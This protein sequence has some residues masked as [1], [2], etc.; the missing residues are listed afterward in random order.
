PRGAQ[1][2]PLADRGGIRE[3]AAPL[4]LCGERDEG[5]REDDTESETLAHRDR[6]GPSF[7][8]EESCTGTWWADRR[9]RR[10]RTSR[11]SR[12]ARRRWPWP[13]WGRW[14]S[15]SARARTCRP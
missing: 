10:R 2:E 3:R 14:G 12:S 7:T 11:C 8:S 4:R 15:R 13:W 5:D 9:R 1:L 6:H